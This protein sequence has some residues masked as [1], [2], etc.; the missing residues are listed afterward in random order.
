MKQVWYQLIDGCF[1]VSEFFQGNVQLWL[2][3]NLKVSGLRKGVRWPLL[4]GTSV[5]TT[6]QVGNETV[7]Q[8]KRSNVETIVNRILSQGQ[9]I[10]QSLQDHRSLALLMTNVPG[11]RDLKWKAPDV[12]WNKVNCDGAVCAAR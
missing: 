6:W 1:P 4:F 10:F 9:A 5:M 7:F 12:G 8:N 3:Q 11:R 2:A